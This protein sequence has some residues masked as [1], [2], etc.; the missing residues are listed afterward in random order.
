MRAV[1]ARACGGTV[2]KMGKMSLAQGGNRISSS[3]VLRKPR[4]LPM[5]GLVQGQEGECAVGAELGSTVLRYQVFWL[6]LALLVLAARCR[7]YRECK[8][9]KG[10]DL[11]KVGRV[12]APRGKQS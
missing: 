10:V 12:K 3:M 6:A 11:R 9:L 8:T 5:R 7:C 4:F 2:R 1:C